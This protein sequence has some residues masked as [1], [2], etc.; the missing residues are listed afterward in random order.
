MALRGVTPFTRR[1]A[2]R[3]VESRMTAE[4]LVRRSSTQGLDESSLLVTQGDGAQVY[5]GKAAIWTASAGGQLSLGDASPV[6]TLSTFISLPTVS[7]P[8][9]LD[10]V[11]E[12]VS[13]PADAG[14]VGRTGTVVE[15]IGG[16]RIGASRQARITGLFESDSWDGS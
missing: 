13:A 14:L 12:V 3:R 16:K 8:L 4:V 1:Y 15:V 10:D 6:R 11:V 9:R 2:R 5:G 7:A